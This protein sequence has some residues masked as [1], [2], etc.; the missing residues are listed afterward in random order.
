[1]DEA[2]NCIGTS[3]FF[4]SLFLRQDTEG[5]RFKASSK[6]LSNLALWHGVSTQ[7][8]ILCGIVPGMPSDAEVIN[9]IDG[10][11]TPAAATPHTLKGFFFWTGMLQICW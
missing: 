5:E 2:L 10:R 7:A 9:K 3:E 1:M 4:E 8:L 6:D 11:V